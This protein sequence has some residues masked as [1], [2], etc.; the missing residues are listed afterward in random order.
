MSTNEHDPADADLAL[1]TGESARELM[2]TVLSAVDGRLLNWAA[3]QVDHEPG[4]RTTVGYTARVRWAD[5]SVTTERLGAC[6]GQLPA[7][8]ARLSNGR[9]EIGMWRFP[10]DPDLT[11]RRGQVR[12][13]VSGRSRSNQRTRPLSRRSNRVLSPQPR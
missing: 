9:T 11:E 3:T 2:A 4:R 5:G 10:F 1:L 7:G 13:T 6:S 12:A 8:V